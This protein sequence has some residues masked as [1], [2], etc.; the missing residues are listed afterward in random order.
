MSRNPTYDTKEHPELW[1]Q[2]KEF[3]QNQI[4]ELGTQ[5]GRIDIMW[6]D[7]GMRPNGEVNTDGCRIKGVGFIKCS[8][9][10]ICLADA[11]NANF[12]TRYGKSGKY[13]VHSQ[14]I[15]K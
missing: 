15:Y 8:R 4:Y 11:G 10:Q 2:F 14:G 5:Y 1:E 13:C 3:T 12:L 6:F 9:L 7:A